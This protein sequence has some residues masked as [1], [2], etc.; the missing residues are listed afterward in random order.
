MNTRVRILRKRAVV[1]RA[2]PVVYMSSWIRV[3]FQKYNG[4][5]MVGG[6]KTWH[7]AQSMFTE[8]WDRHSRSG[9]SIPERP[10]QTLPIWLHGDEGRGL[11]KK[12]LL[13]IS[14]Q[15]VIGW[16]GP[17]AVTSSGHLDCYISFM[18]I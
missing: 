5:Y 8:F 1:E 7:E 17:T 11:G 4:F 14:F 3:A 16:K 9:G 10:G 6:R 13:V 2:W 15:P 12:P 18:D